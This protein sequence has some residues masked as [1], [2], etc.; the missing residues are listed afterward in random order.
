MA[1]WVR[2]VDRAFL[3]ANSASWFRQQPLV[4]AHH[5]FHDLDHL[6]QRT[7]PPPHGVTETGRILWDR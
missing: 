5:I 1:A 6:W 3:A 2:D 4:A 7:D